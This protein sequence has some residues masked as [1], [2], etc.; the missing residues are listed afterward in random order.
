M[1]M[2]RYDVLLRDPNQSTA[3][4]PAPD[5]PA[6]GPV[7]PVAPTVR[8]R[9]TSQSIVQPTD[10]ATGRPANKIVDRP[11]AFY[12]TERLDERLDAAVRYYQERHRIHKVDRSTI[13]NA[14]LD[15]DDH[16]TDDAL[17]RLVDRVIRQLTSRLTGR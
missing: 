10:Q 16:W 2:G 3:S 12:I 6:A 1:T 14:L 15:T 9:S 11:K 17:D 13:V 5:H 7:V 4:T 8:A